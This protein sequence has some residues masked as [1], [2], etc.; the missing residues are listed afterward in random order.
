MST[1]NTLRAKAGVAYDAFRAADREARK[2]RTFTAEAEAV[3][4]RIAWREACEKHTRETPDSSS[5]PKGYVAYLALVKE[6]VSAAEDL[7]RA[8]AAA[9]AAREDVLAARARWADAVAAQDQA[10]LEIHEAKA[11][12]TAYRTVQD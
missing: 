10:D 6:T 8:R 1:D 7:E 2:R 11:A 4:A 9:I 5:Y 3:T 12:A